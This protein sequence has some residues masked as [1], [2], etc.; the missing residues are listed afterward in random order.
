M[1]DPDFGG[2][3]VVITGAGRGLGLGMA[4][5][6]GE[7]G[8]HVVVAELVAERG[9]QAVEE[10]QKEGWS[11]SFEPLDVRDP[12]QSAALVERV[13][14]QQGQI[15]VW[16]NNAGVAYIGPAE[17]LPLEHWNDSLAVM[18]SGSFY[19]AQAVGRHMLARGRGVIVNLGSV[20]SYK[21]IEE[22]VAYCTAKAGILML[23]EMLGI[24]WAGRGVR[25]VG[26][27]PGPVLTE[28]VQQ[29][30]ADGKA[31]AELYERRTPLHRLGTVE[32]IAEAVLFLA[33]DEAS[34]ITAET[35]RVDGGW[36][37]YQLF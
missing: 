36:V 13:V 15:D 19:C 8:A 14:A 35:L 22:R 9:Q 5:R 1:A 2:K 6:F 17:T 10:L 3:T 4:R 21:A 11:A 30:I 29:V 26:V 25:V 27:A 31:S 34:Y 37:A 7:V 24:E 16:V 18:L 33:S 23:T 28:L 20:D 32:D 12:K